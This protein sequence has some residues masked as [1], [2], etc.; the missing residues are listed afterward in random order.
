M[1]YNFLTVWL[2]K[3]PWRDTFERLEKT[4][5]YLIYLWTTRKN[6]ESLGTSYNSFQHFPSCLVSGG[7]SCKASKRWCKHFQDVPGCDKLFQFVLKPKLSKINS[8]LCF[9]Q[10]RFFS[11]SQNAEHKFKIFLFN[12][13][14][15]T[16]YL[17]KREFLLSS[18]RYPFKGISVIETSIK[19]TLH[20][21]FSFLLGNIPYT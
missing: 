12:F 11:S 14:S 21:I 1:P 17:H 2:F 13:I 8:K 18:R 19:H 15:S 4:W 20:S 16:I 10:T 6:L 9:H 7:S 3:T 5:N